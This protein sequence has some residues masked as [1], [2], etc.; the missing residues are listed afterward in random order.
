MPQ[1]RVLQ[2]LSINR[3]TGYELSAYRRGQI[4]GQ[5]KLGR[6]QA[7]IAEDLRVAI[8]TVATTIRRAN[9]R[10]EGISQPRAGAPSKTNARDR[11][12]IQ[13]VVKKFPD[14]SYAKIR[15][16][17]SL[18][19]SSSTIYRILTSLNMGHWIAK[20]RPVLDADHA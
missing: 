19:L 11:R 2:D 15:S 10:T 12:A 16:E 6:T 4:V 8:G 17:T 18:N 9:T 20:K 13:R 14:A 7:Q 1:R 5:A 3:T